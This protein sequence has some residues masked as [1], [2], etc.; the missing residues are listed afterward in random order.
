MSRS[1]R[2]TLGFR[3][4]F[5]TGVVSG[6]KVSDAADEFTFAHARGHLKSRTFATAPS[7]GRPRLA[8]E[9]SYGLH[10]GPTPRP[11]LIW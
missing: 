10:A 1:G 9:G 7:R 8:A 11:R 3:D 2:P 5:D 6:R 4:S